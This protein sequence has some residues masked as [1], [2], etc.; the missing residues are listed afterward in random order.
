MLQPPIVSQLP[1]QRYALAENNGDAG[2]RHG[3]DQLQIQE[4]LD[5]FSA[6]DV[7]VPVAFL[8]ESFVQVQKVAGV[9]LNSPLQ[10]CWW[11]L[12]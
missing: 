1:E 5:G 9:H 2:Q 4:R 12:Y 10:V 11:L 8:F 7:G 6:I 3:I